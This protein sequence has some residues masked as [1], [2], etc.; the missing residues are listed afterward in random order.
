M[1]QPN[2]PLSPRSEFENPPTGFGHMETERKSSPSDIGSRMGEKA[3]E[4]S[5]MA[6][7]KAG[8]VAEKA[9]E[10]ARDASNRAGELAKNVGH[11]V[12]IASLNP[13]NVNFMQRFAKQTGIAA[14][15]DS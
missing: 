7:Q 2:K 11:K 4:L 1:S 6:G 12:G 5:S 10:M 14:A 3:E 8:A 13:G 9:K 15:D